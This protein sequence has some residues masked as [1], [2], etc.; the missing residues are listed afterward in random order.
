MCGY[1]VFNPVF[2]P[3]CSLAFDF[4]HDFQNYANGISEGQPALAL[5]EFR[6]SHVGFAFDVH[7]TDPKCLPAFDFLAVQVSPRASLL[8]PLNVS[9]CE[10][11]ACAFKNARGRGINVAKPFTFMPRK[12][13]HSPRFI[14]AGGLKCTCDDSRFGRGV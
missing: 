12:P 2:K 8:L 10:L 3:L 9:P 1:K 6:V 4:F 13:L 14:L 5:S 7:G 11:S